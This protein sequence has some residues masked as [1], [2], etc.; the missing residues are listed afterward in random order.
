MGG[1][2]G[3]L[4]CDAQ[5]SPTKSPTESPTASPMVCPT[6]SIICDDEET[7]S[8]KNK[9]RDC[10]ADTSTI[11]RKCNESPYW[12]DNKYCRLSCYNAQ[13][14]YA[15]DLCCDAQ[16]SPTKSPTESPTASPMVCPTGSIICDDKETPSQKNNGR[17]C[18]TDT[19]T[20]KRKCNE[21]PFWIVNK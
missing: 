5:G 18:T 13:K 17:D 8:Q 11:K 19:S 10:T 20:I 7:P 21:S 2:A 15:G 6:G 3:D 16:G 14:G 1:Y 9:G 4:C 12:R